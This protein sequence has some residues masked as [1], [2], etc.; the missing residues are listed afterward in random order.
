MFGDYL[1]KK[2]SI[3][4][5]TILFILLIIAPI[6]AN[7]LNNTDNST[8]IDEHVE[9][10]TYTDLNNQIN[11]SQDN[12]VLDINES[13]KY[14]SGDESL[15]DGVV[16]SKNITLK[17]NNK[18]YIDGNSTARLITIEANCNVV[19]E[20][21]TFINGFSSNSGGAIQLK[22]NSSLIINNCIF[23]NNQ[24]YNSNGGAI[25]AQNETYVE[26]HNSYFFNNTSIRESDLE[27]EEFKKGMGSA[28][29]QS[30]GSRLAL[31]D[32]TFENNKAYLS[33]I[34]LVS[35]TSGVYN[36]SSLLIQNCLF[37][38]NTSFTSGVVYLD[39]LG[40]GEI[41]DSIFTNNNITNH[42]G[43]LVLDASISA[44]V[45]NCLFD[46]NSAVNGGA[47]HIKLYE[48][49]QANVTIL[50]CNFTKNRASQQGGVIYSNEGIV[51]IIN[52]TFTD[53]LCFGNGGA[54]ITTRGSINITNS[55]F[56][57]NSAEYGGALSLKMEDIY[58]D[59]VTFVENN[60]NIKGAAVYSKAE[61][62]N[63]SNCIYVDNIS[64]NGDQV[65]GAFNAEVT[66]LS[67]YW[68]DVK[69]S[70]QLSSV[71]QMPLNQKV[72]LKFIGSSNYT[73]A[74]FNTTEK[75][76]LNLKVPL[77]L[78][79]GK[80]TL[81][82]SMVS[83]VCYVNPAT[84]NVIKIPSRVYVNKLTTTYKSGKK[85]KITI[86]NYKTKKEL[87]GIKLKIKVWTG[88]K[89]KT[90]TLKSDKNGAV[91][92]DT[93]KLSV[94]THKIEITSTNTHIILTKKISSIKIKKASGKLSYSKKV[95]KPSKIKITIKN[96]AS[97]KAIKKNKFTVKVYTG[98]KFKTVKVTS[99][100]K[101]VIK[102]STKKLSKGNH[103]VI[104]SLKNKCYSVYKKFTVKIK[105]KKKK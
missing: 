54:I 31:F 47:M 40:Q 81:A 64:P 85:L 37:N 58:M 8:I 24:V 98:K 99:N 36:I 18:V 23:I 86:K 56:R 46:S 49:Y 63:V 4:V 90:Y 80:Y 32:S 97:G 55:Y 84:I 27:W 10:K 39:E 16:I 15:I 76:V 29:C 43:V 74:W 101:G 28:I 82:I 45:K 34:L 2:T 13:Y 20:N 19:M 73:T 61:W 52:S 25:N 105:E 67:L 79:V 96:K 103:K 1:L 62:V 48:Q 17:G 22:N 70:I 100:S 104:V 66:P 41:I 78:K 42:S 95:K 72:K 87:K 51:K 26:I 33:T 94:G 7:D 14:S 75:G 77:N 65:Y 89:Y 102:I 9:V 5:F 6:Q 59:N 21:I 92:F 68:D 57:N 44:L 53:N 11:D 60:A 38:N 83:G 69:L 71:W 50:N 30:I 12:S 88:K 91:K 35:Y 93:S 3:M